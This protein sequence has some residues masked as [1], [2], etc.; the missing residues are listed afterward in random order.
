MTP[1]DV[2]VQAIVTLGDATDATGGLCGESADQIEFGTCGEF[3]QFHSSRSA[4]AGVAT[5][6]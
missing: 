1:G 2:P 3:A 4:P 5:H 6:T